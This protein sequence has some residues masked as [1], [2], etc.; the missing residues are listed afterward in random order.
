MDSKINND[1][2]LLQNG[3]ERHAL[4]MTAIALAAPEKKDLV[5]EIARM[6][7]ELIAAAIMDNLLAADTPERRE[8]LIKQIYARMAD[9]WVPS[10][11][12]WQMLEKLL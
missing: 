4:V 5:I 9:R 2:P 12:R 1:Y 11:Q 7:D 6:N 3:L 8:A 10:R